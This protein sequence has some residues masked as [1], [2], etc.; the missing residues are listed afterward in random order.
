MSQLINLSL[1]PWS[2]S[3]F[4]RYLCMD[5]C[6]KSLCTPVCKL[7]IEKTHIVKIPVKFFSVAQEDT[8]YHSEPLLHNNKCELLHSISMILE[9][10]DS[11]L[12]ECFYYRKHILLFCTEYL[13]GQPEL[14]YYHVKT[15][16][17]GVFRIYTI[18]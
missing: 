4:T 15:S 8:L 14:L 16:V 18:P 5:S 10:L 3:D 6:F 2:I 1:F 11:F 17:H 13:P 9:L 12:T 7:S